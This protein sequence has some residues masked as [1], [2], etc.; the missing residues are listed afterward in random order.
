MA[1]LAGLER[2][3]AA[4][5]RLHGGGTKQVFSHTER[6]RPQK[7]DADSR[8]QDEPSRKQQDGNL[9]PP[10]AMATPIRHREASHE[11][12]NMGLG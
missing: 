7:T 6:A 2:D 12:E 3:E 1:P 11:R 9:Y 10:I 8:K 5:M 4:H